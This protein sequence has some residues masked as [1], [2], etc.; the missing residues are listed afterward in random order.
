[1][2]YESENHEKLAVGIVATVTGIFIGFLIGWFA[3]ESST[4]QVY[5]TF[6][7]ILLLIGLGKAWKEYK[8]SIIALSELNRVHRADEE[9]LAQ[10]QERA[11]LAQV[12]ALKEVA[13]SE[14]KYIFTSEDFDDSA[15]A[16]LEKIVRQAKRKKI[17]VTGE[18]L[19][20]SILESIR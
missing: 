7:V 1:M 14:V 4:S 5:C 6:L 19:L 18:G 3:N 8:V 20:T 17:R 13:K 10:K 11:A 12:K 16:L 2:T 15:Q 9:A